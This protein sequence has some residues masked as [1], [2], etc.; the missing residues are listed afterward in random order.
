LS[1]PARQSAAGRALTYM[2]TNGFFQLSGLESLRDLPDFDRLEE[3]G[4][5]G[6]A[7]LPHELQS[8]LGLANEAEAEAEDR[9]EGDGTWP[10]SRNKL[11]TIDWPAALQ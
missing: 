3:A 4:L 1:P 5:L 9:E 7:P 6:K 11:Q 8:A 2:T 10:H